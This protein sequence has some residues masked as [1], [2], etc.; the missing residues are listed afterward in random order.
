MDEVTKPTS[1]RECVKFLGTGAVEGVSAELAENCAKIGAFCDAHP[2]M[3]GII[4]NIMIRR[5]ERET[6]K[7]GAIDWS[8]FLDWLKNGGM[9]TLLQIIMSIIAMF[10]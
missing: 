9:A 2:I 7:V 10:G 4:Q 6:G 5:Y 8:A 3:G 1:A